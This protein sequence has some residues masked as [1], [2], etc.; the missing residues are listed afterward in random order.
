MTAGWVESDVEPPHRD[1]DAALAFA[2]TCEGC[3]HRLAP[4]DLTPDGRGT[5]VKC[6]VCKCPLGWVVHRYRDCPIDRVPPIPKP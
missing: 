6:A 3:P 1:D 5:Q 4:V 2:E